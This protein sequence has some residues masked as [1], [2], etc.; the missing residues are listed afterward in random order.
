M[1]VTRGLPI[2][3]P[4][5]EAPQ[6]QSLSSDGPFFR[7]PRQSR[8]RRDKRSG[9]RSVFVAIQISAAVC[10][11]LVGAFL[12]T[13]RF[14]IPHRFRIASIEVKGNHFLSEG[15][16]REMLGPAMGGSLI[17]AD[18]EG[19]RA[20][21]AASPWVG[22]AVV[23]RK[24]PDT[25]TVD[26]TERFP[27]AFAETDQLYVMDASGELIDLLGPRTAGFDLPVIRGLGG[28]SME[29]RRDR[30]RRA[31][32]LLDDLGDLSAEVSEMSVDASGDLLVVLRGDGSVL[33][34]AEPPYRR[35][36]LSFLALRQKLRERCPDAEYFDL[37]F[38]DRIYAKPASRDEKADLTTEISS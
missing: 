1:S 21:L 9:M 14:A 29:V 27:I 25:L 35:R 20:N 34:L 31:S 22:G 2:G 4:P 15:E 17:S 26:V 11:A 32:V 10:A 23:R 37:R 12:F 33:K 16:V 18:L 28:V 6:L 19:L 24:L 8:A 5:K 3:P 38:K 30:A 7:P 13:E 36:V